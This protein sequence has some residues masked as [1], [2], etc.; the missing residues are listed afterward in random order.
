MDSIAGIEGQLNLITKPDLRLPPRGIIKFTN[1]N[2]ILSPYVDEDLLVDG[3][4]G[5]D[6]TA[7]KNFRIYAPKNKLRSFVARVIKGEEEM[8]ILQ[9]EFFSEFVL[10][11]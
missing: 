5:A 6:G 7:P 4:I 1:V 10:R 8:N 9:N 3:V 2:I 11:E